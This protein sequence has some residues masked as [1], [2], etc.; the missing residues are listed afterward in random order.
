MKGNTVKISSCPRSRK[1]QNSLGITKSLSR[2]ELGWEGK[3]R[4]NKP[5]DL[6]VLDIIS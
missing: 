6:S 2:P 3:P 5:E 1:L 4:C